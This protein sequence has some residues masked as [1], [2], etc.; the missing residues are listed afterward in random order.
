MKLFIANK[1]Y[2]SWSLRPWILLHVLK[3][4]FDEV[5]VPFEGSGPQQ[6][7]MAFSPSGR[8]VAGLSLQAR[9]KQCPAVGDPLRGAEPL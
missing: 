3:E 4:P 6:A 9:L 2:S 1:N 5:L 7:F 8:G